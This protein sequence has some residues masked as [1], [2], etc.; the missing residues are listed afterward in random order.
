V[1]LTEDDADESVRVL[2]EAVKQSAETGNADS[3]VTAYRAVPRLLRL[4]ALL[5][6]PLDEFLVRPLVAHDAP[7]A[8]KAGL[9]V[10]TIRPTSPEGLTEREAEVLALLRRGLTNRQIAQALW[11]TESTAKV[12]VRHIFDKLGVRSRTAAALFNDGTES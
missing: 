9:G 7:L 6:D 11:I 3:F 5:D 8:S 4:L 12:H 1:H 10:R 2:A